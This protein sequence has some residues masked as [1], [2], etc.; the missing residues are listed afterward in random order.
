MVNIGRYKPY[1]QKLSWVSSESFKSVKD[2]ATKKFMNSVSRESTGKQDGSFLFGAC[3]E[4]SVGS[5]ETLPSTHR[6]LSREL[7]A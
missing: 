6:P 1:K 5:L 7:E 2:P 4:L 3:M